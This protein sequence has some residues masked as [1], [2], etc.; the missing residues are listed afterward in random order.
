ML[1]LMLKLMF[2]LMFEHG[3]AQ[4]ETRVLKQGRHGWRTLRIRGRQGY[5]QAA[6]HPLLMRFRVTPPE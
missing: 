4:T 5:P 1:S 2:S 3:Y 6:G